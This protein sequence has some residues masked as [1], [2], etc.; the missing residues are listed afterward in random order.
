[1]TT[2]RR[3]TILAPLALLT[4]CSFIDD[5]SAFTTTNAG[6]DSG[7][8]DSG[9]PDAGTDS[10]TPDAGT[11]APACSDACDDDA[12]CD[13]GEVCALDDDDGCSTCQPCT[14]CDPASCATTCV[15]TDRAARTCECAPPRREGEPCESSTECATG[16]QCAEGFGVCLA[17]CAVDSDCTGTYSRCDGAFC[18]PTEIDCANSDDD[19]GDGFTDCDDFDCAGD[20]ACGGGGGGGEWD[21]CPTDG[22]CDTG[23]VCRVGICMRPCAVSS[24]CTSADFPECADLDGDGLGECLPMT[25]CDF[26]HNSGCR[27]GEACYLIWLDA[28]T[29]R[30]GCLRAR[31]S[32]V[33]IGGACGHD[34]RWCAP[35]SSCWWTSSPP[36]T[37]VQW[38]YVEEGA[39]VTG[40]CAPF[41]TP[42][43][44]Y[45]GQMVGTCS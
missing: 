23:L 17:T 21:P 43:P 12:D 38:C 5:W 31:G 7:T 19:D 30:A 40:T 27:V 1:M 25:G 35:G 15:V 3:W 8:P 2:L 4:G 34:D 37:C 28:E 16:L 6:M 29:V 18:Y 22:D 42:A 39:C 24:D 9:T 32:I 36:G 10:G 45:M 33:P 11:D 41:S 14:G 20:P 13:P 26:V 44:I